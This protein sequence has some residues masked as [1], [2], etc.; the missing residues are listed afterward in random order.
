M[1]DASVPFRAVWASRGKV[2][3]AE[4]SV[5]SMSMSASIMSA[6]LA[7]RCAF[8]VDVDCKEMGYSSERVD[9]LVF[10]FDRADDRW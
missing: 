9:A 1:I 8:T 7:A 3:R 4:R 5:P 6:F 2:T 10:G